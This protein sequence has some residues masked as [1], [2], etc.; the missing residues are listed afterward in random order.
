MSWILIF[1]INLTKHC[2]KRKIV[3]SRSPDADWSDSVLAQSHWLSIAAGITHHARYW[4]DG[5]ATYQGRV[6]DPVPGRPGQ[7]NWP[8]PGQACPKWCN[9]SCL[10]LCTQWARLRRG[11]VCHRRGSRA[12]RL[13]ATNCHTEIVFVIWLWSARPI[14][15]N[16]NGHEWKENEVALP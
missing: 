14:T 8:R 9:S 3:I 10:C 13:T 2:F 7:P 11:C 16:I 6:C 5:A 12:E 1:F 15:T 4:L